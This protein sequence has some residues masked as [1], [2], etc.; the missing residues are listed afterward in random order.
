MKR[1]LL[2]LGAGL[3]LSGCVPQ[4]VRPQPPAVELLGFNLISLDPF[5]GKADF[6]VRLRLTNPN[7]FTLPLLD[8]TITAEL[9]GTQFRLSVPAVDLPT[10]SPREV[11]TRLTVPVV[12]GT[13]ALAAL[14]SGQSIRLRLLGELQVRLGPATVPVGPFTLVDRDV[15]LQLAF[16]LPTIRIV[17]LGL[18]GLALRV[19]LEV[20]NPNPIGFSMTGPLRVLVGGQSVAQTTL[21]LP[22][23]PGGSSR[24]EFRLGLT[25]FPGMGGISLDL[26]LTARVPGILERPVAQVLQGFLR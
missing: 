24:G 17:S 5:S 2:M 7:S 16:Q 14:V 21:N 11:Q 9:G 19:L 12:E 8:S 15:Q 22:L 23:T 4:V 10:N 20:Q 6:D 26:G 1:L 25:G 18:D 3:I 13:R